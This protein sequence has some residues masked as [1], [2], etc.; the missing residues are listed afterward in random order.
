MCE[1]WNPTSILDRQVLCDLQWWVNFHFC[2]TV[3]GV[4]LW[5]SLPSKAIFT[6]VSSTLDYGC[7]LSDNTTSIPTEARRAFGS[8]WTA[9]Q[10]PWHITMKELVSVRLRLNMYADKLRGHTVRLWEDNQA[11]VFIIRNRTPRSPLFMVGACYWRGKLCF[12]GG[13]NRGFVLYISL[14]LRVLGWWVCV[15]L[16]TRVHTHK[17]LGYLM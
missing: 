13:R 12:G 6:D 3:N 17:L 14:F 9:D 5:P 2:S 10:I 11:V 4:P 16:Y 15:C 8:Y 1:D 7:V